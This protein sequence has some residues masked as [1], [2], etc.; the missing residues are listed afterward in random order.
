M[1]YL[2]YVSI[3]VEFLIFWRKNVCSWKK[4]NIKN[5]ISKPKFRKFTVAISSAM[6]LYTTV[7]FYM[8]FG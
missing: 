1:L 8:H 6:Q 5:E 2:E 4:N 3:F 7:Y